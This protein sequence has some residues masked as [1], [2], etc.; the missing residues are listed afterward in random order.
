MCCW[1]T[2]TMTWINKGGRKRAVKIINYRECC[3]HL[4][5]DDSFWNNVTELRELCHS[6]NTHDSE[7]S[8]TCALMLSRTLRT[9]SP[10]GH[11]VARLHTLVHGTRVHVV[12][13]MHVH[14]WDVI[15]RDRGCNAMSGEQST[16]IVALVNAKKS[17][18]NVKSIVYEVIFHKCNCK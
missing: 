11:S 16:S 1:Q 6:H 12:H 3:P 7:T 9:R 15:H 14:E 5:K 13:A 17:G 8:R 2:F 4:S 18:I 10:A